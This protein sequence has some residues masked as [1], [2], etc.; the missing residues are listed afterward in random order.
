MPALMRSFAMVIILLLLL[1]LFL[2][3]SLTNFPLIGLAMFARPDVTVSIR[4]LGAEIVTQI[5]KSHTSLSTRFV[6]EG[7]HIRSYSCTCAKWN[8]KAPDAAIALCK[9]LILTLFALDPLL[10]SAMSQEFPAPQA[11]VA[12][13]VAP[14]AAAA[15]K[16]PRAKKAAGAKSPRAYVPRRE[17]GPWFIMV[18]LCVN[19]SFEISLSFSH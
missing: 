12:P 6:I 16:Q 1:F 17:T 18:A 3:S 19:L 14:P 13:P 2:S 10:Y 8:N 7:S 9:H 11:L 4:V 15:A 5:S